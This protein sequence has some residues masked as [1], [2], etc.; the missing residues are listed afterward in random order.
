MLNDLFLPVL[1][2]VITYALAY[3]TQAPKDITFKEIEN[4]LKNK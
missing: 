2:L 3:L 1:L 4:S